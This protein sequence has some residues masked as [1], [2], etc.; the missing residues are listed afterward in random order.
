MSA[1]SFNRLLIGAALL[2]LASPVAAQD[3]AIT[4]A[5]V[6]TGDGSDPVAGATVVVR[7]GKVVAAGRDVAV[8]AGVQAVD[9][10]GNWGTTRVLAALN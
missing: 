3:F 5:T 4:N 6:A 1:S 7:G 8:P 10:T 9:G 2:A